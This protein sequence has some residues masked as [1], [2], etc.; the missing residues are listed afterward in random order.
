MSETD[1]CTFEAIPDAVLVVGRD[2]SVAYGNAHAARMFGYA[3]TELAGLPL[4]ALLPE[5]YR[6]GHEKLRQAFFRDAVVRPMG[7]G[8]ELQALRRNG[9]EF[10]V[11]IAIGPLVGGEHAVAVVRDLTAQV[12]MGEALRET[13]QRFRIAA[14]QTADL[15]FSVD[16]ENDLLVALDEKHDRDIDTLMGYEPGGFPRS[17]TGWLESIHPDDLPRVAGAYNQ[18][19][20]RGENSWDF[21]FR[22]R[23]KDGSYRHWIDR[24]V[25][26]E[27]VDG[28]ANKGIGVVIDQTDSVTAHEKLRE[29]EERFR[30][31][32]SKTADVLQYVNVEND[33]Y[34]WFGDVDGLLGYDL[35]EFPRTF[36][37][38]LEQIHPDDVGRIEA[39][40]GR[41]V[42]NGESGWDFRYRIRAKDGS[43]RDW[44]DRGT[45]TEF[46]DGR[47]NAGIGAIVDET[48]E[49]EGRRRLEQALKEASEHAEFNESVLS[50]LGGHL[51]VLDHE[52]NITAVN[53]PWQAFAKD[54]D[55]ASQAKASVG[56][57]YLEA[58]RLA[59]T[60]EALQACDGIRSVLDRSKARFVMEY[61]CHSPTENR[62]FSMTVTPMGTDGAIVVHTDVTPLMEAQAALEKS[63]REISRLKE[64][65]EAEGQYL[66]QEIEDRHNF[67]E[68]VGDSAELSGTL[69]NLERVAETNATVLLLGETGTGKELLA[70]ATHAR[71]KRSKRPLIKVD[72]TTLPS[73]LIESELFGHEKGSFTGAHESKAG[74][75]EL[76]DGGTIFLD[77]VG[78]LP[79]E[80]QPK[81]LRVIQEGELQR[82][83][84]KSVK[85][86][87][88]RVI[89]ATHRNLREEVRSGRFRADL[90]YRLSVFP[91]EIPA[92]RDRREDIPALA[93]FFVAERGRALGTQVE[94]I[95]TRTMEQLTAYD[96][97]G[98]IRELQ[99]VIERA[100]IL[101][102]GPDLALAEPLVPTGS[103]PPKATGVLRSDL[104]RLER[105]RILDALRASDWKIKG[106]GNA[107]SLLGLKPSTLRSRM[108]R[109]GVERH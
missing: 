68:I 69:H 51:A 101:S 86:V 65:L 104:D 14:E 107:A 34:I 31:A 93:R 25:V 70:R 8:R 17:L 60:P 90:Y 26:T 81:L 59:G 49:I 77:E 53:G 94:R 58:C 75:F 18:I 87:D 71:S 72:C 47:A 45:V 80:L 100:I 11:E 4:E 67:D 3:E 39:E 1:F 36:T 50:S 95:P 64:R 43:Y 33:Q 109:L 32:A 24:G 92:L 108:K 57:N 10:P 38:W 106:D 62:W 15:V 30:I 82:L 99:N 2:G 52:G 84:G 29:S 98:N 46:I 74:R 63:V 96:W 6:E 42:A 103:Q 56:A 28:R 48:N 7:M 54:N 102:S 35:G 89:A 73:G 44:L 55:A 66:R 88:V 13:E 91:V 20:E 16:V 5:K 23:A 97:P 85:K 105:Q 27:F 19:V 79:I 78:E 9:K 40:A 12:R 21:R 41:V 22:I 37:G 61:P 76:A 83:G